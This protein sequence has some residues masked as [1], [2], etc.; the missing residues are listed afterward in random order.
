MWDSNEWC[1]FQHNAGLP[2]NVKDT[3]VSQNIWVPVLGW[4]IIDDDKEA[5]GKSNYDDMIIYKNYENYDNWMG[6]DWINLW[7]IVNDLSDNYDN[8]ADIFLLNLS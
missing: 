3:Q 8:Y 1:C 6:D 4:C 7:L 5:Q 2:L